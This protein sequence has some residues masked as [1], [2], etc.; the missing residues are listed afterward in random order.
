MAGFQGSLREL[1]MLMAAVL[2]FAEHFM[3]ND[4]RLWWEFSSDQK[5]RLQKVLFPEGVQFEG[6][7]IQTAVT[8]LVFNLLPEMEGEKFRMATLPGIEPGL[9]P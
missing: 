1:T 7:T 2:K 4:A 5:Q 6:G 3:L 8:C 9:P